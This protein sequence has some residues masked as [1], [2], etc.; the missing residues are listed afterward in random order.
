MKHSNVL[1]AIRIA[2][3]AACMFAGS[4]LVASGVQA[5][6]RG[7]IT[8]PPVAD[9]GDTCFART[10]S[11]AH[12]ASHRLQKIRRIVLTTVERRG[13]KP[14]LAKDVFE[15]MVGVQQRGSSRWYYNFAECRF[16]KNGYSCNLES[17]GGSFNV[18]DRSD[19]TVRL[20]TT[21]SVRMEGLQ[22]SIEFGGDGS[23]DNIFVLGPAACRKL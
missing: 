7:S 6:T 4:A 11:P 8:M 19:G 9:I 17:D 23:D 2:A 1:F 20:A 15:M 16:R 3:A 10:Y 13:S 5:Q 22:D 12:L 14:V 21:G 18:T